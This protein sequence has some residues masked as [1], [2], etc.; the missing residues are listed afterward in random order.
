METLTTQLLSLSVVSLQRQIYH[1]RGM[2]R[3]TWNPSYDFIVVG[4]GTAG[5]IVAAR[6]TQNPNVNVL[7]L[8][9]GGPLTVTTDM[10]PASLQ[11]DFNG[12]YTVPQAN[13]GTF[14]SRKI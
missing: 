5:S 12:Y 8:E 1:N 4:S 7:L 10:L 11:Y 3:T 13:A 6:L 14:K 9:T 2:S